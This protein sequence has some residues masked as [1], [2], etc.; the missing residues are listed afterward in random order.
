MSDSL[1]SGQPLYLLYSNSYFGVPAGAAPFWAAL[2]TQ[3]T[4]RVRLQVTGN[5]P[6]TSAFGSFSASG[7]GQGQGQRRGEASR[8]G[9]PARQ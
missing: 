7:E 8:Q 3:A 5:P 1:I 9:L 4:G 2:A 6:T